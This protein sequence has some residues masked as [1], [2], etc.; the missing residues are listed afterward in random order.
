MKKLLLFVFVLAVVFLA[1][2]SQSQFT[3][4]SA[5]PDKTNVSARQESDP[6]LAAFIRRLTDRST[7]NLTQ[8]RSVNGT[9]TLDLGE[10]FQNV[11]LSKLETNGEPVAACVTSIE[12][13]NAFLGRNLDT[14]EPVALNSFRRETDAA[15]AARHGISTDEFAF[16]KKLIED[17]ALQR[18]ASPNAATLNIVN[19]DGAGEG[20]NDPTAAT[21]E[22]NNNGTTRGEQRL[23]LFNFA[24]GIWGAYLDTNVPINI[25]SEFNSLSP[26]TTAGG[27]LGSAGTINIHADFP[28]AQFSG[29]WYHAALANKLSGA[30]LKRRQLR[31]RAR[32]N[33]DVDTGCLGAGTR[34]YYGLDNSTPSGRINLLVVLLHEMGHGLGFSN[35]LNG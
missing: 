14:G 9:R 34:F 21:P 4:V 6:Q 30:D 33:S 1:L 31:N 7:G 15:V 11:M 19:L 10:G 24:A 3:A 27:V 17:A 35:F 23:N 16:Y 5:Q 29:T 26:C 25:N 8:N 13:A 18:A 28:G 2:D 32:F 20:F 22:G 12:E